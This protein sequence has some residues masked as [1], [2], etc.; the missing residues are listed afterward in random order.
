MSLPIMTGV[1]AI[2]IRPGGKYTVFVVNVV[3]RPSRRGN[4]VVGL[5]GSRYVKDNEKQ[6]GYAAA[7]DTRDNNMGFIGEYGPGLTIDI[8]L[9]ISGNTVVSVYDDIDE[10][11][12][13][14]IKEILYGVFVGD[15]V[16]GGI[17]R[18]R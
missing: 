1:A 11:G 10:N 4:C 5:P 6:T 3:Q 12:V 13:F 8:S 14:S 15:N 7:H 17:T 9:L 2:R 18:M 16:P